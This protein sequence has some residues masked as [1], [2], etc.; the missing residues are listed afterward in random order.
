LAHAPQIKGSVGWGRG[1]EGRC[2]RLD[3]AFPSLQLHSD[4]PVK[5]AAAD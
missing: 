5:A 4:G 3:Q 1:R 2:G